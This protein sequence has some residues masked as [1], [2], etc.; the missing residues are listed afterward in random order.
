MQQYS[1]ITFCAPINTEKYIQSCDTK[2]FSKC[3]PQS[4]KS[5]TSHK[6]L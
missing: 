2:P 5:S 4:A 6:H 1:R 3:G